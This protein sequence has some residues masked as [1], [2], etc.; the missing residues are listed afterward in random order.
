MPIAQGGRDRNASVRPITR[1]LD[2]PSR[3]SLVSNGS[4][5]VLD[6]RCPPARLYPARCGSSCPTV[7]DSGLF[8]LEVSTWEGLGRPLTTSRDVEL[9][10]SEVVP[11]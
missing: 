2:P 4:R 8:W 6:L 9:L 7:Q 11:A 5:V 3:C 1:V 10:I